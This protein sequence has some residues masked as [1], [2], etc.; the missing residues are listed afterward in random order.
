MTYEISKQ[1]RIHH[2][3]DDWDY[4]FKTD[5]D[6]TVKVAYNENLRVVP[7]NTS[8]HIPKDC[9]NNFISALEQFK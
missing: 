9:I 2:Q 6:G 5:V 7:H 8:I 4:V 1:V 3:K